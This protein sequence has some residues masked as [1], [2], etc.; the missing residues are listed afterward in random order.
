MEAVGKVDTSSSDDH[1][2]DLPGEHDKWVINLRDGF[3]KEPSVKPR[4]AVV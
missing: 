3:Q 2:E 4:K 1:I